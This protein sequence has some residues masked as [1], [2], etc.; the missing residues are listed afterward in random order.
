M[1]RPMNADTEISLSSGNQGAVVSPFGASLRRYFLI[2]E[3]S[4]TDLVWGYSGGARKKGGQGDVLIPFPGRIAYGRYEFEGR[5]LQLECN[6]KE[7]PNAIHGFLRSVLW[8]V[9]KVTPSRVSFATAIDREQYASRGYPFSLDVR[10]TYDL[11]ASGLSCSFTIQNVGADSAPVGVGFHPYFTVGT[12]TIDDAEVRIPA[13]H[14]L[15]LA[16]TLAPTGKVFPVDETAWDYREYRRIDG[17]RLNHCYVNLERHGSGLCTVSLRNPKTGRTIAVEMDASF[18]SVVVYTGDAIAQ[19]PRRALA[20]EPMTC[21]TDAFNHP[22]WGLRRLSP[23]EEFTGRY[24]M[25]HTQP[26]ILTHP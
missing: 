13:T 5:T 14:Y 15:E 16:E 17:A 26:D 3:G 7:G 23:G 21:A 2:D 12:T 9:Q 1:D 11:S 10:M 20:L 8:N 19:A 18:T 4:E 24:T 22:E 6:D 25:R